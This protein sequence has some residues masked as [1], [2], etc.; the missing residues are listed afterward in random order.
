MVKKTCATDGQ[1]ELK[2]YHDISRI[3]RSTFKDN[4]GG[5]RIVAI[6]ASAF[7]CAT[8]AF[9]AMMYRFRRLFRINSGAGGKKSRQFLR[10]RGA[11][12][13][14][15]PFRDNSTRGKHSFFIGL[16]RSGKSMNSIK[17][18]L[19]CIPNLNNYRARL[20]ARNANARKFSRLLGIA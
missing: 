4:H 12:A 18:L 14:L 7:N 15:R 2:R 9:G 8:R 6:N 11:A 13:S 1:A 16:H 17:S 19:R 5:G 20:R 10:R 3:R